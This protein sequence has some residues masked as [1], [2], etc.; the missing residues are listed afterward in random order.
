MRI[1]LRKLERQ[2]V[3]VN[4]HR[5]GFTWDSRGCVSLVETVTIVS[6]W[7]TECCYDTSATLSSVTAIHEP[8]TV[9]WKS[10]DLSLFPAD[11]ISRRVAL[12]DTLD[13][14]SNSTSTQGLSHSAK[15]GI[16][17]GA[18]LGGLII[19]VVSSAW[20][21][22]V[23]RRRREPPAASHD[24]ARELDGSQPIWKQLFYRHWRTELPQGGQV[25][26]LETKREPAQ[27]AGR[28]IPVEL[29]G[30]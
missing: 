20:L 13:A 17:V 9:L 1:I 3:N 14:N 6:V 5:S 23:R 8:V 18:A 11:V 24:S 4:V 10:E 21:Y 15:I 7:V 30:S 19:L 25:A 29:P 2:S 28:Q 27:L 16:G 22:K 12:L 26:E